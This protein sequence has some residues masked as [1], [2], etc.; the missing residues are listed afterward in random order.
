MCGHGRPARFC[1]FASSR[2]LRNIAPC[3]E[4]HG[5]MADLN[6]NQESVDP[7]TVVCPHP[8]APSPRAGAG[9]AAR[10]LA[11]A[12]TAGAGEAA[13]PLAHA[14]TAGAGAR[15]DGA[16]WQIPA[17]LRRQM[18]EVA[19]GF[20][21]VPTPS[22]AQLWQALRGRRLGGRRFR[23]QQ[24]FGPFVVDFFCGAERLIVEVDGAVH[25]DQQEYDQRRQALLES[26]GLRVLR[27][28]AALVERNLTAALTE[29]RNTFAPP[30]PLLATPPPLLATLSPPLPLWER[31]P[32]G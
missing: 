22:E 16:Y 31:G 7:L 26:L 1:T 12:P 8:P 3:M 29:I 24:P 30:P 4:H 20:R 28:P 2:P 13:R 32:G 17:A 27:L 18:V 6:D 10:P 15:D 14:P 21:K 5:G 11:H 9:E 19:R 23:R 25:D